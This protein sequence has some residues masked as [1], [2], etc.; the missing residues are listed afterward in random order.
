MIAQTDVQPVINPVIIQWKVILHCLMWWC[1]INFENKSLTPPTMWRKY[2]PLHHT[3]SKTHTNYRRRCLSSYSNLLY[4]LCM[5]MP[6]VGIIFPICLVHAKYTTPVTFQAQPHEW[7]LRLGNIRC[8]I[9]QLKFDVYHQTW[10]S[11][12]LFSL[13]RFKCLW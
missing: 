8:S 9:H 3:Q 11:W 10:Q 5:H 13:G 4:A 7:F 2:T 12:Q 6:S 1:S